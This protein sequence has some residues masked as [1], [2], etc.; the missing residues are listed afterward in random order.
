MAEKT[1]KLSEPQ[2]RALR[3]AEQAPQTNSPVL[4]KT[5]GALIDR[6]LITSERITTT[7]TYLPTSTPVFAIT[8]AGRLYLN[9]GNDAIV[10]CEKC[11]AKFDNTELGFFFPEGDDANMPERFTERHYCDDCGGEIAEQYGWNSAP[12]GGGADMPDPRDEPAYPELPDATFNGVGAK[13][14]AATNF[15]GGFGALVITL[16]YQP[17]PIQGHAA[18]PTSAGDVLVLFARDGKQAWDWADERVRWALIKQSYVA[19]VNGKPTLT[20]I[21]KERAAAMDAPVVIVHDL[22]AAASDDGRIEGNSNER[23]TLHRA[24]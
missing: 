6:G 24:S 17:A 14:N 8:D 4:P 16:P 7:D 19:A 9:G 18:D 1:V 22:R 10:V 11:G 5:W 15:H 3:L 13:A 12:M 21:G 23:R 2:Q 20:S